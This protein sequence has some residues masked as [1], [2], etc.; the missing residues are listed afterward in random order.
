VRLGGLDERV[1]GLA[2]RRSVAEH[3]QRHVVA[4]IDDGVLVALVLEQRGEQED[5]VVAV[6]AALHDHLGGESRVVRDRLVGDLLNVCHHQ[7][8]IAV[9]VQAELVADHAKVTGR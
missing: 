4:Q 9:G 5:L 3:S 2:E 8:Q 7:L 1:S 6:P